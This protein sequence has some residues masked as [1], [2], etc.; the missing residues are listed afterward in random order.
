MS[1]RDIVIK[2]SKILARPFPC[3]FENSNNDTDDMEISHDIL[4]ISDC[5]SNRLSITEIDSGTLTYDEKAKLVEMLNEFRECFALN[6]NELGCA[7]SAK[8]SIRLENDRPSTYTPYRMSH[9]E[10]QTVDDMT[11]ELLQNNIIRH[12]DSPYSS[13][14]LL[15]KKENG[16]QKMC[17]DYRKLNS[18]TI[19]DRYPLPRIDDQLDKLHNRKYYTLDLRS[20]Y[21]QISVTEDSR[22]FT[23]FV[24]SAGNYEFTRIPFGLTNAPCISTFNGQSTWS[25]AEVR[26]CI[27]R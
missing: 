4:K 13:P 10:K 27:H 7:K 26:R 23:A 21:Y 17:I 6:L 14:I 18:V 19:K 15:V 22:K 2:E 25:R 9:S 12:S 16:E 20:G 24:T 3:M 5:T 11:Q 1:N 8:M